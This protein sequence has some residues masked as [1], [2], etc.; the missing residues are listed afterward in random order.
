MA[1]RTSRLNSRE[2][3][4]IRIK[5]AAQD[6]VKCKNC[7]KNIPLE[8]LVVDHIDSN[9]LNNSWDNLQLLCQKCNIIKDPPYRDNKDVDN[10]S[11]GANPS[12]REYEGEYLSVYPAVGSHSYPVWK[13]LKSEPAFKAW[14][15]NMMIIHLVIQVD[16][17]INDGANIAECSTKTTKS[18]L[19]KLIYQTGP[20]YIYE[21]PETGIRYLKWKEQFFPHKSL[22][23]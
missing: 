3:K 1:R 19:D 18:Y 4:E 11:L 9:Y 12:L 17:V 16:I 7:D 14:L 22:K 23:S 10:F 6:G 15:E 8:K 20:Y 2:L 5:L 13:N 21:D